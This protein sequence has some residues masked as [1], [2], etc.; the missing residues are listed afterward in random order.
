MKALLPPL[1]EEPPWDAQLFHR[2]GADPAEVARA[3]GKTQISTAVL[4]TFAHGAVR[5]GSASLLALVSAD[6]A[7]LAVT[8]DNQAEV[9]TDIEFS[10][11]FGVNVLS[12]RQ[13][14]IRDTLDISGHALNGIPWSYADTLP[15][16]DG[17]A[18]WFACEADTFIR[19]GDHT[20]IIGRVV[21]AERVRADPLAERSGVTSP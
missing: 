16:I 15:Q 8:I 18:S 1:T 21:A 19:A 10:R 7:L 3:L 20:I 9:L 6:P 12:S 17:L 2:P 11:V 4:S 5:G 13:A 14:W